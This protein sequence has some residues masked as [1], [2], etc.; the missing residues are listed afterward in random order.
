MIMTLR[1]EFFFGSYVIRANVPSESDLLIFDR[2]GNP[3]WQVSYRLYA[4]DDRFHI[5]S[6]RPQP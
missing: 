4:I 3:V 1:E 5:I 6:D 2:L